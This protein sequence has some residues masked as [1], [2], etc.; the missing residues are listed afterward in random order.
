MKS[1]SKSN[2]KRLFKRVVN[3][4]AWS[5][6]DRVRAGQRYIVGVCKTY[7]VPQAPVRGPTEDFTEAKTRLHLTD[8]MLQNRKNA[9]LRLT[10]LMLF[11]AS[12]LFI[13][14]LYNL[15]NAHFLAAGL[16]TVVLSIALVL[17]FR[18]H[19][20]YFQIKQQKLGC[21]LSEWFQQGLMGKSHE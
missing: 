14:I 18:Y 8:E 10:L 9:L 11:I 1:K 5:D 17:A 2:T 13:Y 4:R 6:F 16:S 12:L 3:P 21:T 15:F 20:W 7:F 19:F